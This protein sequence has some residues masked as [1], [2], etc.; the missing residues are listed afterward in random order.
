[1]DAHNES[2][3][4]VI[5]ARGLCAGYGAVPVLRDVDLVVRP[6]ELVALLGANG[7]GK[8]TTLKALAGLLPPSRGSVFYRGVRRSDSLASRSRAGLAY[9]PEERGIF[10]GLTTLE[11]LRLG[12]GDPA[13]ALELMP[14]LKPLVRRPAGLLSGGEQQ[15]LTIARALAAEPA[16][17]LCDELS[18]GLAPIIVE[19][20]LTFIRTAASRGVAVLLVEQQAR[21]A[22]LACDRAYVL[23]RGQVAM[24]GRAADLLHRFGEVEGQYLSGV[25]E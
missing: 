20:L 14:E 23:R 12:R 21:A 1:M 13:V 8:T 19:R 2:P 25:T 5:E 4:A 17:F 16:I 6:G 11:N 18:L 15:M 10:R 22:L 7:A 3:D 9:V 24:S